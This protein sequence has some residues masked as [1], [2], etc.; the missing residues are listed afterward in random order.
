MVNELTTLLSNS[1]SAW[2]PFTGLLVGA[3]LTAF[4]I[5]GIIVYIYTAIALMTIAKRTKTK[6]P[7]LAWIPIANYY[8]ITKIARVPWWTFFAFLLVL[9]PIIGSIAFLA[10]TIWW[11]W[12]IAEIRKKPG[13]LAILMIIPIIN[14]IIMGILAWS[15]K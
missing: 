15:K 3:F 10:V 4:I 8:L 13:W 14:L 9:I 11:W 12:K 1:T 5:A 6:D 7:W 2:L